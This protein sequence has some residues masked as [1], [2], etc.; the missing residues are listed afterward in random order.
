MQL[1]YNQ[2]VGKT[3]V[4]VNCCDGLHKLFQQFIICAEERGLNGLDQ[5]IG[6][7]QWKMDSQTDWV[8]LE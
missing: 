4:I 7:A 3:C 6:G 1:Q 8:N 5:L 2:N